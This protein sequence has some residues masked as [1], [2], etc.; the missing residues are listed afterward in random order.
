[1]T[2]R[3]DLTTWTTVRASSQ[4]SFPSFYESGNAL[5]HAK[6][7]F[8]NA[9]IFVSFN[10]LHKTL[11]FRYL[12]G[13]SLSEPVIKVF[14]LASSQHL[15]K[16]LNE[17]VGQVHFRMTLTKLTNR[18][19]LL[20]VQLFWSGEEE[21]GGLPREQRR[22]GQVVPFCCVLLA[23]WKTANQ[24]IADTCIGSPVALRQEFLMKANH[25]VAAR[26]PP[27]KQIG[28]IRIDATHIGTTRSFSICSSS[29]P[30]AFGALTHSHALGDSGMAHPEFAQSY[31]LLITGA[32][33]QFVW[34]PVQALRRTRVRRSSKRARPYICLFSNFRRVICPSTWP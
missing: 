5:N 16:L 26:L 4:V 21:E 15:S 7:Q 30:E 28:E 19:L 34:W 6:K 31:H 25:I 23:Y 18:F 29:K 24:V 14:S 27:L 22:W 13:E 33:A 9:V 12:A 11:Q 8:A 3:E 10:P 2:L 17:I 20:C 32:H 1:V